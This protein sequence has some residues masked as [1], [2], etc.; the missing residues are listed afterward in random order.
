MDSRAP[1][2]GC[3]DTGRGPV[4]GSRRF[5]RI[6]LPALS[7]LERVVRPALAGLL[8]LLL[9]GGSTR[10][11]EPDYT[12][13]SL[14]ELMQLDVLS[15]NV[16]GTHT[17]PAGEWMIGYEFMFMSMD[18]NRDGTGRLSPDDVLADFP[19]TPTTMDMQMHMIHVMYAPSNDWTLM[20]MVPY[21]RLSMDHVMRSGVEFTT[22]SAGIGDVKVEALYTVLGDVQSDRHRLVLHGGL[23]FPSGSI[24]KKDDLP[25]GPNQQLP[26]PMQLGSGTYVVLI[27]VS[28]LGESE[29]WAWMGQAKGVIR[30]GEND[31]EYT[32]GDRLHVEAWLA[33]RLTDAL[34]VNAQLEGQLWGNHE[35]ADPA[36]NPN[37]VPTADPDRRGGERLDLSFGLQ[38]YSG[39]GTFDGQRLGVQIGFP[40][41]Q[42]LNGPQLETDWILSVAWSWTF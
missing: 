32:V 34:A 25:T 35:G 12:E 15:T 24:D 11:E 14:E 17:H 39:A 6:P 26:Y 2:E 41:Y 29:S 22:K 18:G 19:V 9:F 5:R 13:L 7:L 37:M 27:G 42:S 4:S 1:T 30:L 20:V 31:R 10:S 33:R 8:V 36:L 21:L 23:S 28:Y 38:L 3:R 16:L 40:I